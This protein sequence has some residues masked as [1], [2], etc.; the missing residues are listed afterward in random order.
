[1]STEERLNE[2]LEEEDCDKYIYLGEWRYSPVYQLK[3]DDDFFNELYEEKYAIVEF[4]DEIRLANSTEAFLIKDYFSNSEVDEDN[5]DVETYKRKYMEL[6]KILESKE[7][8]MKGSII[9][10]GILTLLGAPSFVKNLSAF[11]AGCDYSK[12]KNFSNYELKK[13]LENIFFEITYPEYCRKKGDMEIWELSLYISE[14]LNIELTRLDRDI[15]DDLKIRLILT[16]C[17]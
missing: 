11:D 16:Y 5:L 12:Y 14:M 2:L 1:M 6:Y 10:T 17:E 13:E 15:I 9:R 8:E 3:Y 7:K 4:E